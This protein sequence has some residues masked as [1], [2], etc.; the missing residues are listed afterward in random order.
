MDDVSFYI[1][2]KK[3]G[4]SWLGHRVYLISVDLGLNN[5]NHNANFHQGKQAMNS[6][7]NDV[8]S[9]FPCSHR[10]KYGHSKTV[11]ANYSVNLSKH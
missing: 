2:K 10:L 7:S 9:L 3:T 11:V 8:Y 5:N 6:I 1:N 4:W